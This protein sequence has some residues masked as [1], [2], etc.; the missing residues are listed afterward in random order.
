MSD[1]PIQFPDG[2]SVTPNPIIQIEMV[3]PGQ[4]R[5]TFPEDPMLTLGMLE[6]GKNFFLSRMNRNEESRIRPPMGILP[7]PPGSRRS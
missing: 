7:P 4:F 5:F 3:A 2:K 1:Q 6:M